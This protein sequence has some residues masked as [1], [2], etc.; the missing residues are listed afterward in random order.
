M[1]IAKKQKSAEGFPSA[2]GIFIGCELRL[3][4]FNGLIFNDNGALRMDCAIVEDGVTE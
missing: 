1:V 4:R 3:G 2:L